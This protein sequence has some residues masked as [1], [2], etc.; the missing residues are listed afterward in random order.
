[1]VG[2]KRKF[3][4]EDE[5]LIEI[6]VEE[7]LRQAERGDE[8]SRFISEIRLKLPRELANA[9]IHRVSDGLQSEAVRVMR[10]REKQGR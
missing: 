5:K 7:G 8:P 4:E 6:W 10:E 2:T 3:T 9:A 1:V